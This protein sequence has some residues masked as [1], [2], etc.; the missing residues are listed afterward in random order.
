MV[1]RSLADSRILLDLLGY[2]SRG[3]Q[4]PEVALAAAARRGW[5]TRKG[6]GEWKVTKA[7]EREVTL[8]TREILGR[9][10]A[11]DHG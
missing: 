8:A 9:V 5:I 4:I 11:K 1:D 6:T 2:A 7:G 3:E 10:K